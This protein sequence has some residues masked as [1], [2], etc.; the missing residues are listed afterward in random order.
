MHLRLVSD[1]GGGSGGSGGSG[2][3]EETE[4]E[5]SVS[6]DVWAIAVVVG[7]GGGNR[8]KRTLRCPM[9]LRLSRRSF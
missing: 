7:G 3:G 5:W 1:C 6:S 9:R 4:R 8:Q 2:G